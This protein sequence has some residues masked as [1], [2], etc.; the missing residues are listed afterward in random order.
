MES[1]D[2][3][4]EPLLSYKIKCKVLGSEFYEENTAIFPCSVVICCPDGNKAV[5]DA[6]AQTRGTTER[7]R[8]VKRLFSKPQSSYFP[9]VLLSFST[10]ISPHHTPPPTSSFSSPQPLP[11]PTHWIILVFDHSIAQSS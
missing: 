6:I 10:R 8:I 5:Y 11:L 3:L 9:P 4:R 1:Y 2:Q 7:R